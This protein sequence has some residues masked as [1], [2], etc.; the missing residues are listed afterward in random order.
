MLVVV[1]LTMTWA[2]VFFVLVITRQLSREREERV[3][4]LEEYALLAR[5]VRYA[6]LQAEV[7]MAREQFERMFGTTVDDEEG[8]L[9]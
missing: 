9:E 5:N 3:R 8:T 4:L 2:A 1:G 6:Q 7:P